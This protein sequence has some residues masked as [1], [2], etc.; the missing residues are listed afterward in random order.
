MRTSNYTTQDFL[1][2]Q[3]CPNQFTDEQIEAM[4]AN[5]DE[6]PDVEAEW[7][8]FAD[9]HSV[10][11]KAIGYMW[12]RKVASIVACV[13][14]VGLVYATSVMLGFVPN[15]FKAENNIPQTAESTITH[16]TK[17]ETSMSKVDA[18]VLFDNAPLEEIMNQFATYYNIKVQYANA[19]AGA[20]RLYFN[21]DKSVSLN[22]NIAQ[23][24]AFEKINI[25]MEDNTLVVE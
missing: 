18:D 20:V 25:R 16:A 23:L 1:K 2:M 17:V 24:N 4:M 7:A 22:D 3:E 8:K 10:D 5:I 21:W 15:V 11:T 19:D 13:L 14:V 12:I 9:A 6:M